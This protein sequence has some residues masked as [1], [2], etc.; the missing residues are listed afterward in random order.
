[1]TY[2]KA[3]SM[4]RALLNV[5]GMHTTQNQ[6]GGSKKAGLVPT[7]TASVISAMSYRTRGL[8][9]KQFKTLGRNQAIVSAASTAEESTPAAEESAPAPAIEDA[10]FSQIKQ[11]LSIDYEKESGSEENDNFG[12]SVSVSGNRAIVG[13]FSKDEEGYEAG[14]LQSLNN[15]VSYSKM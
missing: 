1:M 9:N 3:K 12:W 5:S 15:A 10:L 11:T 4:P 14:S 13:A 6:G 8:P 2:Y 7:E